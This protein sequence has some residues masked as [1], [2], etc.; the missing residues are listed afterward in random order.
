MIDILGNYKDQNRKSA[1]LEEFDVSVQEH[2][3]HH[4]GHH[5]CMILDIKTCF[6]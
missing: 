3:G 1:P 4:N 5:S 6:E 2:N